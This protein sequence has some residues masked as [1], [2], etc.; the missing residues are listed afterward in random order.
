MEPVSN[1]AD[2]FTFGVGTRVKTNYR[3]KEVH[4][5]VSGHKRNGNLVVV[6]DDVDGQSLVGP[7]T[8]F[9][10]SDVPAPATA[11]RLT[12]AKGDRV[13]TLYRGVLKHG[14]VTTFRNGRVTALIDGGVEKISG[15]VAC[16]KPSS[17]VVA[18]EPFSPLD[19]YDVINYRRYAGLSQETDAFTAHITWKGKRAI[20]VSN[21]GQGGCNRYHRI[22][23]N[24][25]KVEDT[26]H[27]AAVA[28]AK[29]NGCDLDPT[30]AA[31]LWVSW[32][33]EP[34]GQTAR[35]YLAPFAETAER[36]AEREARESAP[37][38]VTETVI[39][40]GRFT[41]RDVTT[42]NDRKVV[43][44]DNDTGRQIEIG[45]F[46]APYAEVVLIG[47]FSVKE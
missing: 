44:I 29:L 11:P 8:S 47:L 30:T 4:G 39:A 12:Y 32:K 25:R 23:I 33:N 10:P 43:F 22:D 9:K 31:D 20:E 21:D 18:P 24:D 15:S 37:P 2:L 28:W 1:P 14:T 6:I 16:F 3:G 40:S 17:K 27:A 36:R 34:A 46:G 42:F 19:G 7:R 41:R 38:V 5:M 26:F 13:E 35:E 45:A